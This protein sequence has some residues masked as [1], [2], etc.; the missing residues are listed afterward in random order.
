MNPNSAALG[1]WR[2]LGDTYY[3]LHLPCCNGGVLYAKREGA[4]LHMPLPAGL[5]LFASGDGATSFKDTLLTFLEF[6][7]TQDC[8]RLRLYCPKN[9]SELAE[10]KR[11]VAN[12]HW[13]GGRIARNEDRDAIMDSL[14]IDDLMTGDEEFLIL[15]F[16]C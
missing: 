15:E 5:G 4:T 10:I 12:L 3:V 16:E 1:Q 13:I 2:V 14:A 6:A 7:S 8:E 9:S 11:I